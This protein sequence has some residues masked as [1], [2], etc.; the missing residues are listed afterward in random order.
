M[1]QVGLGGLLPESGRQCEDPPGTPLRH[2]SSFPPPTARGG[3][4]EEQV[5]LIRRSRRITLAMRAWQAPDSVKW[6]RE[7]DSITRGLERAGGEPIVCPASSVSRD[8]MRRLAAWHFREQDVRVLADREI[9]VYDK[10]P[11]WHIQVMGFPVGYSG[12]QSWVREQRWLTPSEITEQMQRWLE[13]H[14]K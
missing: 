1:R 11:R 2:C 9:T 13:E 3:G 10:Q 5:S 8:G 12:C 14:A 6:S 4:V 7:L